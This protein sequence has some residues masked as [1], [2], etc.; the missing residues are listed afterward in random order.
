MRLA[1]IS[2]RLKDNP[3]PTSLEPQ[4][5]A[6]YVMEYLFNE[7]FAKQPQ[8]IRQYLLG[9]AILDRFCVP[10]CE[11][12]CVPGTE[13]FSCE[14]SGWEYITWL[15]KE[16]LFLIPLDDESRWFRFHHL[17]QKLLSNQLKRRFSAEDITVLHA[18]ASAWFADNGM[19]EEAIR[20]GLAAGDET[21]AAQLVVQNRQ[22]AVN[23]ERWFELERWLSI[24]PDV[25][26]RQQPELLLAQAWIH[27]F[28]YDYGLIPAVIERI[29]S[30]LSNRPH[31]QPLP[32]R[33]CLGLSGKTTDR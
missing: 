15:K 28:H 4:A 22:A 33:A 24:L 32:G 7:V 16:N 31:R 3:G 10:L 17:F 21:G 19:I 8:R 29:E 6:Q 23:A 27:Y 18:R 11:A 13:V 9:T 30:L 20:H 14:Q 25:M 26:I 12:V 5:D 1:A 2:M